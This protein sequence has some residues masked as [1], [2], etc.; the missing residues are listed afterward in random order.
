[1]NEKKVVAYTSGGSGQLF[2]VNESGGRFYVY[3]VDVG[4]FGSS[5]KKIGEARSLA[6]A[7]D[8]IKSFVGQR[9]HRVKVA[10]W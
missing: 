4:F 1:M 7:I 3:D 6:D 10:P 5:M 2:K 9:V 8:I